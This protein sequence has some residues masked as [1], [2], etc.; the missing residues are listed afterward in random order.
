MVSSA[1]GEVD[2]E[3]VAVIEAA[4]SAVGD[5]DTADRA[6]LLATLS[7]ELTY[8][9]DLQ[10]QSKLAGESLDMARRLEDPL[11]FLRVAN[12]VYKE[13]ALP[14][15]LDE[16]LRDLAAAVSTAATIG[17][18][19]AQFQAHYNLALACMQSAN[20]AEFDAHLDVC[21]TLARQLDQ[22]FEHWSVAAMRSGW[23][24]LAGDLMAAE[25]AADDALAIGGD[26]IPEALT[27]WGAQLFDIRHA[28]GRLDEILDLFAQAALDNPGL[29]VLRAA[30]AWMYCELDQIDDARSIIE[31]DIADRFAQ[32]SYDQVRLQSMVILADVCVQIEQPEV[33]PYLYEELSPWHHQVVSIVMTTQGPVAL[34]LG[35]LATAL[36]DYEAADG[37]FNES[38]DVSKRLRAPYLTALTQIELAK[39]LRKRGEPDDAPRASMLLAEATE[40]AQ[41]YGFAGL[42]RRAHVIS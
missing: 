8:S 28:Q 32:F 36:D 9:D 5:A 14:H 31:A 19:N 12:V 41:R 15:N 20:R 33:L 6:L 25:S 18:P 3:R 2:S 23:Y 16:R 11:A 7:A 22:P 26:A 42:E 38:L 24:L 27:L 17:D 1:S 39:M 37:H 34:Y 29:P 21:D 10:R 35:I 13:L 40:A 30:L 4:L